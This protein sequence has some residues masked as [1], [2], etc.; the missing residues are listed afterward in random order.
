MHSILRRSFKFDP[1]NDIHN[2][3]KKSLT[4][5]VN[6]KRKVEYTQYTRHCTAIPFLLELLLNRNS[7]LNPMGT[8]RKFNSLEAQSYIGNTRGRILT[9]LCFEHA[10][11]TSYI[12][13]SPICVLV[14]Y[15]HTTTRRTNSGYHLSLSIT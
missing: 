3:D 11:I 6:T 7:N 10:F 14:D 4:L 15:L 8:M 5:Q 13:L 9:M 12:P 2:V 1:S